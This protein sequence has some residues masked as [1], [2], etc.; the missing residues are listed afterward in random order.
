MEHNQSKKYFALS[1]IHGRPIGIEDFQQRGFDLHN[2]NHIIVLLGDYFD[3]GD[4]NLMVLRFIEKY[5]KLLN[6]RFMILKG[7]HDDFIHNFITYVEENFQV[8]QALVFD[9][10]TLSHWFR[11]GGEITLKQLFGSHHGIYTPTKRKNLERLK[12]FYTQLDDYYETNDYIFTHACINEVREVDHWDRFFIHK[13]M[14]TDKTV[15]IGHTTHDYLVDQVEF[16]PF[17]LGIVA[18]SYQPTVCPVY[19]IDNGRGDNIVVL[20][21]V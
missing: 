12:Q 17:G 15:V 10:E 6:D 21:E 2:P 7:N 18:Q 13:G 19:N 11:N 1:D 16:I 8:G 5:K 20:E 3:R 4:E 9:S 14:K